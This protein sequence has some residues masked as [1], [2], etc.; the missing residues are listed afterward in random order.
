MRRCCRSFWLAGIYLAGFASGDETGVIP[1]AKPSDYPAIG[2]TGTATLAAALV[3]P[4]RVKK[5]LSEDIGKYYIVIE[6]A[7]YPD[8]GQ[9]FDVALLD[10][11]L[12]VDDQAAHPSRP[13]DVAVVWPEA[14]D[15][16]NKRGPVVNSEAGVIFSRHSGPVTGRSRTNIETWEGV[17]VSNYPTGTDP[18]PP[19]RNNPA[20]ADI[21]AKVRQLSLP[22]TAASKPIAGYLF[23]SYRGRKHGPLELA[24]AGDG[25]SLRF[26]LAK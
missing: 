18:A 13:H 12:L 22:E 6:V 15:R 23:F 7:V 2:K 4:N 16:G 17:G 26:K 9:T 1:R 8:N 25:V 14:N 3:P 5:V 10:F 19:P 11:S 20:P 21:E 24:F